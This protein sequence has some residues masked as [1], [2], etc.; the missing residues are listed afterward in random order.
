MRYTLIILLL[1][2]LFSVSAMAGVCTGVTHTHLS[3]DI[4]IASEENDN[5]EDLKDCINQIDDDNISATNSI[6]DDK[7]AAITSSGMVSDA[8]IFAAAT[9]SEWAQL[10]GSGVTSLHYHDAATILVAT[11]TTLVDGSITDLHDHWAKDVIVEDTA[12]NFASD[13]VEGALIELADYVGYASGVYATDVYAMR[14]LGAVADFDNEFNSSIPHATMTIATDTTSF[15]IV[16]NLSANFEQ[17]GADGGICHA[18]VPLRVNTTDLSSL[19]T[20]HNDRFVV[21]FGS[22][23]GSG[24]ASVMSATIFYSIYDGWD[25]SV[26]NT[27][28]IGRPYWRADSTNCTSA[29][30]SSFTMSVQGM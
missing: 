8:A 29:S 15:G 7:L 11:Y 16:A 23:G 17:I 26:T 3:G 2:S 9:S 21:H 10:T 24:I 22:N 18:V 1:L 20:G 13:T 25:T 5:N 14:W 27:V 4:I 19:S 12:D 28:S 6:T 30:I